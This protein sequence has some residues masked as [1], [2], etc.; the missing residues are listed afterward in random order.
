MNE[1]APVLDDE[2]VAVARVLANDHVADVVEALNR[3]P[4]ET[5]IELLCAVPFERLVEIFD[6]PELESAPEL[7]EALPRAKA[8]RLLT[9]MSVDRAADIL[10]ELD[11]PARSELLGALAPPLRATLLSILGY[12]EGSAA[13]IMTTEFVSVPSDWTV[14]RTLDYIRK[15][16]RTRETVYAIYITDPQTHLLLRATGLRRLITGEPQDSILSVAPD[17]MPVTVTPLTDRETL[18][19][20]ISK[21]DLLAVPVVD[22][23]KILGIVTIDDII[24]T[25]V[26]ETTEDVHRFGGMGALDEPYMKMSFLAMIQKRAG[27]LCALFLS[28]ML[29]ANAMQSYDGELEKAIVL[30]LFIPLIMSSGGNSGSQATSLV[31]RALALREIGLRDWWRVALRELPT[32]LVLGSILGIVG[33]CRIALWQYLGLYDYGPHWILIAATVG[34]A[35]IGIVTFGSLSGSM[36]PFALKRIGFDPASAS[37]PFVATL[38][39]VTGLVIYFSVALVIL[40]GTLL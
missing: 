11:E 4:R 22:Q 26:E 19:Q 29:T 1:F 38:V 33:I 17:R 20:T 6:Q 8:S 2:A 13:S 36:L 7:A 15:V 35:L 12:P 5:A 24:D 27:W 16:E 39:D 23:G 18:A 3:E 14:D 9:A 10:R 40:R 25:M 28:E 34:A 21:Y 37:A 31:I 30:T 32:G